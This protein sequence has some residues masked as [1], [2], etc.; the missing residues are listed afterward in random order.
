MC[1]RIDDYLARKQLPVI[2]YGAV[3]LALADVISRR[4]FGQ[5][6]GAAVRE[7]AR[8]RQDEI[9]ANWDRRRPI[10]W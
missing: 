5:A 3:C 2:A 8:L 4:G 7:W 9:L 6:P 10:P 1:L